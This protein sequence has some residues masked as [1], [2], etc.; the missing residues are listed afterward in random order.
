MDQW[1][2]V[3]NDFEPILVTVTIPKELYNRDLES[4]VPTLVENMVSVQLIREKH[5]LVGSMGEVP[6]GSVWSDLRYHSLGL[7]SVIFTY[8]RFYL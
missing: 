6:W 5:F 7:L 1:G 2:N 8:K 3:K 4:S